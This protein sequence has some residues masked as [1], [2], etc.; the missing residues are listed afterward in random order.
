MTDKQK[1]ILTTYLSSYQLDK[2]NGLNDNEEFVNYPKRETP[3]YY[4]IKGKIVNDG[5]IIR[6]TITK[7]L[8]MDNNLP[9]LS[10]IEQVTFRNIQGLNIIVKRELTVDINMNII[11]LENYKALNYN[12]RAMDDLYNNYDNFIKEFKE[13]GKTDNLKKEYYITQYTKF[14][15]NNKS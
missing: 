11:S 15:K 14:L 6:E 9:S 7:V 13:N 1:K 10:T 3:E 8:Y 12:K 4:G 2:F 5:I